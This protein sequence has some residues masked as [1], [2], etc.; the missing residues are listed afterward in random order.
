MRH[1]PLAGHKYVPVDIEAAGY[2]DS[3][4]VRIEMGEDERAHGVVAR[5]GFEQRVANL[6]QRSAGLERHRLRLQCSGSSANLYSIDK[7]VYVG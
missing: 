5:V 7:N 2:L 6:G 3:E 1:L 4:R